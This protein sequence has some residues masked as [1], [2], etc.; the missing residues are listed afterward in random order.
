[1]PLS[2]NLLKLESSILPRAKRATKRNNVATEQ[3][4]KKFWRRIVP[5]PKCPAP[6]RRR[7]NVPDPEKHEVVA[8]CYRP[9]DVSNYRSFLDIFSSKITSV[10]E[11]AGDLIICGD[12]NLDLLKVQSDDNIA[13][14]CAIINSQVPVNRDYMCV[15]FM[16]PNAMKF[17]Q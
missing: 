14:F 8:S 12:F 10:N 7:R 9:P 15:N 11:F 6:R 17:F 13:E 2:A 1:M 4:K 3:Q 5:A 16:S